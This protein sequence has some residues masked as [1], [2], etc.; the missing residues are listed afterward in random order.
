MCRPFSWIESDGNC[1]IVTDSEIKS[2]HGQ[3]LIRECGNSEDIFGHGFCRS[4][5]GIK[6]GVEKEIN[7]WWETEKLHPH[8]AEL[9]SDLQKNFGEMFKMSGYLDL[10]GLTTLPADVKFPTECGYLDLRGLTKIKKGIILPSNA[11]TP[12]LKK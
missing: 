1:Y 4:F 8:V 12:R 11:Y 7:F 2:E 10:S 5:Y 6:G 9:V 3:E